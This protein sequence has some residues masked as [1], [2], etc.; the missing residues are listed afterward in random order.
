MPRPIKNDMPS[1]AQLQDLIRPIVKSEIR[2]RDGAITG[3]PLDPSGGL[4]FTA[5]GLSLKLA[6][7]ILFTTTSGLEIDF[8]NKSSGDFTIES[9]SVTGTITAKTTWNSDEIE[10]YTTKTIL[11]SAGTDANIIAEGDI[12]MATTAGSLK[13]LTGTSVVMQALSEV[14]LEALDFINLNSGSDIN[15]VSGGGQIF[16]GT[17]ITVLGGAVGFFGASPVSRPGTYTITAA[18]AVATA[19]NADANAGAAYAG[20]PAA[21]ANAATRNDLNDLR[22]DV[23][24][25]SSILRQLIKHLGD[26]TGLGLINETSY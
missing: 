6:E 24:N 22:A 2:R 13:V 20:V 8:L 25:L 1:N 5:D 4:Q 7:D 19:L 26:T 10:V 18:P 17:G 16:I 11:L 21:L 3:I 14:T 12:N 9:E 15:I 23:Q